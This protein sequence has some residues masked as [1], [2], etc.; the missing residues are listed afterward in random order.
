[1]IDQTKGA[2]TSD[3]QTLF[4]SPC[5]PRPEIAQAS[6]TMTTLGDVTWVEDK[7]DLIA[8]MMFNQQAIEL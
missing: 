3:L 5:S 2:K 4:R 6:G 7:G 8:T 1:M